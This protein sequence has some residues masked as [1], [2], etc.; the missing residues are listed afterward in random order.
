MSLGDRARPEPICAASWP[1]SGRPQAELAL[2]LQRDRL[3]VDPPDEHHVAVHALD[4]RVVERV[5]GMVDPFAFG[6]K[7]LDGLGGHVPLLLVV[8]GGGIAIAG[9]TRLDARAVVR[10]MGVGR[11]AGRT[12]RSRT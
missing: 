4:I 5:L 11:E 9:L 6:G 1:S 3:G 7:E 12:I 8:A 10:F 2:A